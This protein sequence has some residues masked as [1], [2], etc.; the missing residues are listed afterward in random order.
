[1]RAK[2]KIAVRTL[3]AR[4]YEIYAGFTG[5]SFFCNVL[6][7]RS[8]YSLAVN[9]DLTVSCTC[10]DKFGLGKIGDLKRET[11]KEILS[12]ERAE[13]FRRLLR[14][15]K[16][17][18][19]SCITCPELTLSGRKRSRDDI[20][21]HDALML[22]NTVNCNLNCVSCRRE[23]LPSY[24]EKTSMSLED[25]KK[26]S[27]CIKDNAIKY[28][29]YFN[30]G[31]PFCSENIKEELKIIREDNPGLWIMTSTNGTVL[32]SAEKMQAA[33]MMDRV[34]FSIHGSTQK[35]MSRYQRD[36]NFMKAYGNM[37]KLVEHRNSMKKSRPEVVWKY[38]LFRWNDSR[39]LIE[40][41]VCMASKA[42]VDEIYFELTIT[43]LK[44]MSYRHFLGLG[45]LD[46]TAEREG[47][48]YRIRPNQ[49]PEGRA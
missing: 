45:H 18:L 27:A 49:I 9:S 24:R 34:V 25:V 17:P 38:L 41:A 42:G 46:K 35:S 22:E 37:K 28:L 43:P 47:I 33:M 36:G 11:L 3:F 40:N 16:L 44:G 2:T 31:E 7:G 30:L 12:G 1:M 4:I 48:Q 32:D 19:V 23:T 20:N 5:K 29:Y 21:I 8:C 6:E 10:N 15:G 13:R 39:D 26:V 14:K